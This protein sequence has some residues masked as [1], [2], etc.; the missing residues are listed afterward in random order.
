MLLDELIGT[1]QLKRLDF[2]WSGR[3]C[4]DLF[5]QL[6][7]QPPAPA[8]LAE[9]AKQ[10]TFCWIKASTKFSPVGV[11]SAGSTALHH[12]ELFT[13]A[14]LDIEANWSSWLLPPGMRT[15]IHG[16]LG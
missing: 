1:R 2:T 13:G 16:N 15:H 4:W 12:R 8:P 7:K 3:K 6:A 14:D 11:R 10:Q 9:E 5:N